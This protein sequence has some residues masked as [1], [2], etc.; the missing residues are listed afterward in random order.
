[1]KES[2]LLEVLNF[3]AP[4]LTFEQLESEVTMCSMAYGLKQTSCSPWLM[5]ARRV[6][7]FQIEWPSYQDSPRSSTFVDPTLVASRMVASGL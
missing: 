7:A 3:M 1:M 2:S 6:P 5:Y 4:K